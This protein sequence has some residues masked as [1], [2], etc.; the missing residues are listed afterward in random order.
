[1][2]QKGIGVSKN[3]AKAKNLFESSYKQGGSEAL[4]NTALLK[5]DRKIEK[6]TLGHNYLDPD[7][8]E[9]QIGDIDEN[10]LMQLAL[11]K[12]PTTKSLLRSIMGSATAVKPKRVR[13]GNSNKQ[14]LI[15]DVFQ[16]KIRGLEEIDMSEFETNNGVNINTMF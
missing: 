14:N 8:D 1:M 2:Y 10:N 9:A 12:D 11:K 6:S 16:P 13:F 7:T 5:A 3:T 15:N 4:V